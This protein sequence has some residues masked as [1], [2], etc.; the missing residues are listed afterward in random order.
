MRDSPTYERAYSSN[1]L[2]NTNST[3]IKTNAATRRGVVCAI[4]CRDE[5]QQTIGGVRSPTAVASSTS[6]GRD[7]FGFDLSSHFKKSSWAGSICS[8]DLDIQ[9][10]GRRILDP[11]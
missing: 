11:I 1:S 5:E 8:D 2:I 4:E 9:P 10:P 7:S 3:L 6:L